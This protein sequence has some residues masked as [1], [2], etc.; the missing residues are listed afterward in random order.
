VNSKRENA[1]PKAAAGFSAVVRGRVQGVGYRYFVL[2]CARALG[3]SGYVRNLPGG[4]VNVVAAGPRESLERLL[5]S[6]HRGPFLARVD[7]IAVAWAPPSAPQGEFH[8]RS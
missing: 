3:L 6:L 1:A 4:A 8:I 7:D 2:E 5:E